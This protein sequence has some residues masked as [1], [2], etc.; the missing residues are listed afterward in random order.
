[1]N[2]E[3]CIKENLTYLRQLPKAGNESTLYFKEKQE[4]KTVTYKFKRESANIKLA[5]WKRHQSQSRDAVTIFGSTGFQN[6][7]LSTGLKF[8]IKSQRSGWTLMKS[9]FLKFRSASIVK[10]RLLPD[11]RTIT[12][13]KV[14][15]KIPQDDMQWSTARYTATLNFP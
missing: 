1:M 9:Y 12:R 5:F 14:F 11:W 7:S 6:V 4:L 3:N 15:T 2:K 10:W 8:L 13:N